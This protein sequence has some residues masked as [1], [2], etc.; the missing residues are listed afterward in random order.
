MA[1]TNSF[2]SVQEVERLFA[3]SISEPCTRS[4]SWASPNTWLQSE[5]MRST[6]A[7]EGAIE[8][9]TRSIEAAPRGELGG[10]GAPEEQHLL[11]W[12]GTA[13]EEENGT[14]PRYSVESVTPV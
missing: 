9:K 7:E 10:V 12:Q 3:R 13:H 14:S 11:I 1:T 5:K 2:G 6:A 4:L 8:R